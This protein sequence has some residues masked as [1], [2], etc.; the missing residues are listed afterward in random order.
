MW[1]ISV[2]SPS[3]VRRLAFPHN[4]LLTSSQS[5]HITTILQRITVT[6][7]THPDTSPTLTQSKPPFVVVGTTNE[8][9]L[10]KV[11]LCFSGAQSADG[12]VISQTMVLEHWVEVAT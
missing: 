2:D 9:F 5:H 12:Q 10:A 6:P 8:P 11:E 7:L 1:M 4:D 3:Y